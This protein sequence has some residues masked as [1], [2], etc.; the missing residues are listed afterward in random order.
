MKS[1]T[2]NAHGIFS[3]LVLCIFLFLLLNAYRTELDPFGQ[4]VSCLATVLPPSV[5]GVASLGK[6]GLTF[7]LLLTVCDQ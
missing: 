6:G 5:Q 1:L 7:L 3:Q 4:K 2:I